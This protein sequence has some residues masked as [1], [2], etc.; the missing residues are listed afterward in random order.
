M[1]FLVLFF[2]FVAL[3]SGL[4]CFTL[5][6]LLRRHLQWTGPTLATLWLLGLVFVFPIPIHGGFMLSGE[7]YLD[8]FRE[9]REE[10]ADRKQERAR[11]QREELLRDE[12]R[13]GDAGSFRVLDGRAPWFRV[14]TGSGEV[15]YLHRPS[16]LVFT[17]PFPWQPQGTATWEQ[18]DAACK[19]LPPE[20][21]WALPTQ[22]ELYLFWRDQ[23]SAVSPWGEGR[24]ISVLHD[25]DLGISLSVRHAGQGPDLLRCVTRDPANPAVPFTRD[26]ISLEAWNRFQLDSDRYR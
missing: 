21:T 5:H 6:R 13:F 8:A 1:W 15:A 20:D 25:A 10:R 26:R 3:V 16:G 22:T 12:V 7:L 4:L 19:A 9:W 23:G 14:A 17:D 24:F 18:A 11:R 2:L